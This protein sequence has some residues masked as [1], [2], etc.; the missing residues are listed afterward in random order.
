MSTLELLAAMK[1]NYLHR[2]KLYAYHEFNPCGFPGREAKFGGMPLVAHPS[3]CRG[4]GGTLDVGAAGEELGAVVLGADAAGVGV[5]AAW[6]EI[7]GG[8][9]T[10]AGA[11]E[12]PGGGDAAAMDVRFNPSRLREF[13]PLPVARRL[14]SSAAGGSMAA[15]SR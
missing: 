14:E 12:E 11:A 9:G 6:P 7:G 2:S 8:G 10:I 4:C 5:G 15:G 13:P 3:P 1:I